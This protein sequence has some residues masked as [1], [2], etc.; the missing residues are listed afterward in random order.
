M[1][2]ITVIIGAIGRSIPILSTSY[3][4]TT[5]NTYTKH[6]RYLYVER[7][8]LCW[9]LVL[10]KPL[11]TVK[12]VFQP[13]LTYRNSKVRLIHHCQDYLAVHHPRADRSQ[14]SV[15]RDVYSIYMLVSLYRITLERFQTLQRCLRQLQR[16][17]LVSTA[18]ADSC[19][20]P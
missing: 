10:M 20:E 11:Y 8:F 4:V 16:G 3:F 1:P 7:A 2:V 19:E 12:S 17:T 13:T 6:S 15:N 14:S 9:L 18:P 5:V